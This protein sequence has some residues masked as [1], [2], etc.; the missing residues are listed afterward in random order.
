MIFSSLLF[1]YGFLPAAILLYYVV[2][3]KYRN[4]VMLLLSVLYC[5]LTGLRYL[6]FITIFAL[7]NLL[8]GKMVEKLGKRRAFAAVPMSVGIIGDIASMLI[9]R[10][11]YF[12]GFREKV[13]LPED[14]FPIGIS[15]LALSAIGSLIDVYCG[16]IKDRISPFEYILYIFFFPRLIM[17]PLISYGSFSK[18]LGHRSDTLSDL[19][20][21]LSL[22]IK[23]LAKRVIFA[24][25]LYSLYSPV[26]AIKAGELSAVTAW[27]GLIA[28]MLCLYFTVSGYADMGTGIARCFGFRLPQSFNYPSFSMGVNDFCRKWHKPVVSWFDKYMYKPLAKTVS[29]RYLKN[30]FFILMWMI[31]GMWYNFSVNSLIWGLIIGISAVLEKSISGKNTP[32]ATS[33]IYTLLIISL[34]FI[35]FAGSSITESFRYFLALIGGNSN[36]AD[37]TGFYLLKSYIV[38]LLISI[39]ASTDLLR[40]LVNRSSLKLVRTLSKAVMPLISL[41]LLIVCTALISYSG[42]AQMILVRL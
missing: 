32:K 14:F 17:G 18:M 15:F 1:I 35:F 31:I 23:G 16:R 39:Y 25:S 19:G 28:Y 7:W 3:K 9:F 13:M 38:V 30:F 41:M 6:A 34:C 11:D 5:A 2:P 4:A 8:A 24:G 40:K 22:F 10:T 42:A 21:G 29:S 12:S 26:K 20:A 33:V 36:I 27:L 37:S